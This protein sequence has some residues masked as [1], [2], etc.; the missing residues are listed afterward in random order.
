MARSTARSHPS[1]RGYENHS[2]RGAGV[3][4]EAGEALV[5]T[6]APLAAATK[7]A[8]VMG[9][10]GGF[11]AVFD[12][13]AAG[14][15]D[16]LLVTGTDGVGTKLKLAI[17]M[18]QHDT[19]GIDLVA[20]SV[21][22]V[23]VQGAEPL[24]FLDYFATGKLDV[25]VAAKVIAGIAQGCIQAGCALVGGETAEMPDMY[26]PGVYDLAGF[27]VGAVERDRLLPANV[28]AGDALVGLYSSGIHS[29]GFSL[30]RKIMVDAGQRWRDPFGSRT[31]GEC[32]LTPT[33]IYA[34]YLLGL[35]Q[36][37]VVHAAAH[38][39]GGGL[40]SNLPRILP[41]GL[42]ARIDRPWGVPAE[43][44]WLR[45]AGG[46]SSKDMLQTFNCGIGM[47]LV[48]PANQASRVSGPI[49]GEVIPGTAPSIALPD[50]EW[51]RSPE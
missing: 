13:K 14:Y 30:V 26:P 28:Q 35:C 12:P 8:G 3:D 44:G 16:P 48:V 17:E 6:I 11:G 19:I 7:R 23:V 41:D 29:N 40:I 22:D 49:I 36:H 31:F 21:N 15:A 42:T 50:E 46:L 9:G 1:R 24:F 45:R 2:Y 10:L 25:D 20:M 37:N 32:F 39:T 4:V 38:I 43:F 18:D 47:V 33:R 51:W 5:R 27:A 34:S